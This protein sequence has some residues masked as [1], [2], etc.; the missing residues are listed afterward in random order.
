MSDDPSLLQQGM[1]DRKKIVGEPF[2]IIPQ[3]GGHIRFHKSNSYL[4]KIKP[5]KDGDVLRLRGGGFFA[6]AMRIRQ[7]VAD[8]RRA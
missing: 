8:D 5:C 1:I 6:R 4:R 3:G 7:G 2:V